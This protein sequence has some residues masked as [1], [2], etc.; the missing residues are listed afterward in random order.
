M[1]SENFIQDNDIYLRE[2]RLSDLDGD[3]YNWLNN[4]SVTV[5][6]NKGI[7]PNTRE[8]QLDYFNKISKSKNDVLLAIVENSSKKHI[9]NVG[10]HNI[11]WV[12][13][14][15]ELG[16]LI[17]DKSSWGKKYGKKAWNLITEYGFN[18]LNLHRI[19]CTCNER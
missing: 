14:S 6:Q 10:L 19:L 12:H 7:F 13:R 15:A 11:D 8:K 4:P 18:T 5:F 1:S 2:I 3:W 17:G 16:I 9:G